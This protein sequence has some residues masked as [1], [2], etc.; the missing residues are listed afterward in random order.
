MVDCEVA[1]DQ[2][3]QRGFPYRRVLVVGLGVSGRG[4]LKVLHS[5][6]VETISVDEHND[7]ADIHD[8]N[9][10]DWAQIDAVV[11]SPFFNPRTPFILQARKRHIPVMS[12]VELA[13]LLRVDTINTGVPAAWIGIT[14]TNGK[15]STTQLTSAMLQAAGFDAP[16]VGNIGKSVSR[17]ALEA[18]HDVLCVELSSFQLHFTQDMQLDCAAITNLAADHLDWHGSMKAYAADKAVVY[19]GVR[20][21]LVY[22]AD[23]AAVTQLAQEAR[24]HVCEDCKIVGVTLHAPQSGQLGVDNGWIVDASGIAGG[25][26]DQ[27][28]R[29]IALRELKYLC[30][31]DGSVY[32]HLLCDALI[33]L[34]L[35]LGLTRNVDDV[36]K[37]LCEFKPGGH[38]IETV[39]TLR[40]SST[41]GDIRFID[42]SKA[43]NAHAAHASLSSFAD[44][45][46]IWIAG[47]LAKG[48]EFH[49]LIEQCKRVMKAVVLIGVDQR[50]LLEALREHAPLLPVTIIDPD[51]QHVYSYESIAAVDNN[52]A[53][54]V[55]NIS[56]A[57]HAP[58]VGK[59]IMCNAVQAAGAYATE[60]DVVMLAP[61]CASMDQ[62][63]SYADRGDCFAHAAQEWVKS[64]GN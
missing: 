9:L 42:D 5:V 56:S 51:G 22:N 52:I 36:L 30:E 23:D 60:G 12:E 46:V 62:F 61:A 38:R 45:R 28:R 1:A 7:T 58:D 2:N 39:A 4:A 16:A 41:Q 54:S 25:S 48:A 53:Q 3:V 40:G 31:P 10:I 55:C 6:N 49:E 37:A 13:W 26:Y 57:K 33:A 59:R 18:S 63:L 21:V 32:P 34:A 64:Y 27:P 43:T 29:M 47:G 44:H 8:F 17:A 24:E 50:P 11:T 14:G 35:T 15:T 19:R 20:K